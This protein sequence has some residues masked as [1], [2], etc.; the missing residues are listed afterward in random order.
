MS[1]RFTRQRQLSGG[2]HLIDTDHTRFRLWAPHAKAVQ[3]LLKDQGEYA[4]EPE[5]G[6]AGWYSAIVPCGAG[7]HYLYRVTNLQDQAL[8]VP[9]PVSRAQ[10]GSVHGHSIVVDPADYQWRANDWRGRPWH[11]AIIYELHVGA[12][13]GFD[14]VKG[15]LALLASMGFTAVEIMPLATFPGERNWGYDGVLPYAPH[16]SY[17][18]PNALKSLVDE[19]HMLGMMIYLDV[20]YNH[21][22]PDGNYLNHYAPQFFTD[23]EKTPWGNAIDFSL[24]EVRNFYTENALYWLDEYRFDG[25]RFDACHAIRD[26]TWLVEV[27]QTVRKTLGDQREI[28]LMA[29]NDDNCLTLLQQGFDAQWN[30]DAHHTLH[31]LLTQENE[32]YYQKFFDNPA[33]KLAAC[34]SQGFV[35][36]T[37]KPE[38]AE[39]PYADKAAGDQPTPP[40]AFVFYLQNHD[41]VGNRPFGERL[42]TLVAERS[43]RVAN[44]LVLLTPHVPMVFMGE[45]FGATQPFLY[46]THHDNPQLIEAV[47]EG[48]RTEFAA[49]KK[50]AEIGYAIKIPD[51]NHLDTFHASIPRPVSADGIST[52]ASLDWSQ[53]VSKLLGIRHHYLFPRLAGTRNLMAK[54]IGPAAVIARWEMGDGA[55]LTL[56]ANL[57]NERLHLSRNDLEI[58]DQA[59]VLFD[60]GEVWQALDQELL[61]GSTFIAILEGPL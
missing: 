28:H 55:I 35:N 43:L 11:E 58:G 44:A 22:G 34:L 32:G 24:P 36:P 30:D 41:Q 2:A 20:V 14:G 49:F 46:F 3:V 12:L 51:P 56:V 52:S 53:W 23:Q 50:F 16:Y 40:S 13:G 15:R 17:G 27:A 8:T 29:E 47:R 31:V 4:L 39:L 33:R 1:N 7:A 26:K 25:L 59:K 60:Y 6:E 61:P 45:E 42:T 37:R 48:R 54:D 57:G 21:F 9:D 38:L 19:A 5:E 18:S 10:A